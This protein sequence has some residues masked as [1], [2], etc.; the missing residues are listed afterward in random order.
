MNKPLPPVTSDPAQV[1]RNIRRYSEEV[2]RVAPKHYEDDA[3]TGVI[4]NNIAWYGTRIEDGNYLFGP[5]K[6]VGYAD[7][8][9]EQ[10]REHYKELNG[11]ATEARLKGLATPILPGHEDYPDMAHAL[12]TFCARFGKN[13]NGRARLA[14]I[15]APSS[16]RAT[17]LAT[18][19]DAEHVKAVLTLI[20]RMPPAAR[21]EIKRVLGRL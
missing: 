3:L 15:E 1:I 12:A 4:A 19:G 9:G 14:L 6:F 17:S 8:T 5:S 21:Q 13:P 11:R 2:G 16:G 10:Y 18:N 20:M 7:I